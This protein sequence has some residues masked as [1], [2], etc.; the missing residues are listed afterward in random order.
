MYSRVIS[1][2]NKLEHQR[3]GGG[4]HFLMPSHAWQCYPFGGVW[5]RSRYRPCPQG[6]YRRVHTRHSVWW[7][8]KSPRERGPSLEEDSFSCSADRWRDEG[9]LDRRNKRRQVV[10]VQKHDLLREVWRTSLLLFYNPGP[11][12]PWNAGPLILWVAE[13]GLCCWHTVWKGSF[14]SFRAWEHSWKIWVGWASHCVH[15]IP[16][17]TIYKLR[18][19]QSGFH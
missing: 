2:Y 16:T 13:I 10:E 15:E 4:D 1:V 11:M 14:G 19:N 18:R 9:S 17:E 12:C 7:A 5:W 3:W 8:Q 6:A